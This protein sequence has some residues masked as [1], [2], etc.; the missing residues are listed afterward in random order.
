ME[1]NTAVELVESVPTNTWKSRAIKA[2]V[3]ATGVIAG[4][5]LVTWIG[6]NAADDTDDTVDQTD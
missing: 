1:G 2:A 5:G 4:V 3:I 6:S